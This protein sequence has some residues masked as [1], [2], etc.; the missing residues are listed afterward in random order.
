M[1]RISLI[2]LLS[3]FHRPQKAHNRRR[4]SRL[5]SESLETRQVLTMLTPVSVAS[6][7]IST[8]VDVHDFDGDG[9]KDIATLN[10]ATSQVSM[11]LGNGDGSFRSG[12]SSSAGGS[13]SKMSVS[14]FDHD[15]K[16]DIVTCQ[17]YTIDLLKGNGDGSFQLPRPYV[18]GPYANDIEI[19]DFNHDGYD[20][21]VT[22][23]FSYG[24]TTEIFINDGLGSFHPGHNMSIGPNG[25]EI[26]VADVDGDGH[27]DLLQSGG[28]G[29]VG[30][31]RGRGDGTFYSGAWANLGYSNFEMKADDFDNDGKDDVIVTD[32][33]SVHYY[34]GNGELTFQNGRTYSAAGASKL[35]LA[36][37]N[38]DG[39]DDIVTNGGTAVL[40]RGNGQ[41]Y[42]STQYGH[43][44]GSGLAVADINGDASPDA[45]ILKTTTSGGG[46]DVSFNGNNDRDLI[47]S[48][49]QLLVSA[50][51][52]ATAGA[53]MTVTVTALDVDGN[54]VPNFQGVVAVSG[55]DGTLPASYAFT[56][57]DNGAH[58]L[59]DAA[60]FF[61]AGSGTITVTSPFLPDATSS[62]TIIGGAAAKFQIAGAASSVAGEFTNVTV[63]AYDAYD[64]FAGDYV[65]TVQFSSSDLQSELPANYTFTA[66]DG[67]T[68]TF[69]A[70]LKTAGN[71]T[72]TASDTANAG[73]AGVSGTL[74]V[75]PAAAAS[76]TVTGGGGYIGSSNAVTIQARDL[77]GNLAT[78]YNGTVHLGSSDAASV[79]SADAALTNGVGTFTVTPMTLGQQT[80][81]AVDVSDGSVLGSEVIDV[82]PGWGV[83]IGMTS[84]QTSMVAGQ[85][86]STLVT[87]YDSFGNVSTVF[88][89]WIK[90]STSD[91]RTGSRLVYFNAADQ[92]VKSIPI[93]LNTAGTQSVTIADNANPLATMT[94]SG[95][96]VSPNVG[97]SA[98]STL[99][100]NSVA[101]EAQNITVSV[102][103]AYGNVATGYRGT[104]HFSSTD[105]RAILPGDYAF[106][107][108]DGGAHTFAVTF[109][110]ASSHEITISDPTKPSITYFQRDIAVSP[111][112]LATLAVRSPSAS[113]ITAG[114][115]S[116]FDVSASDA[117]GNTITDYAGT[118]N[119]TTT[120]SRAVVLSSYTFAPEDMGEHLFDAVFTTAGNHSISFTDSEFATVTGGK[121]NI[122]VNAGAVSRFALTTSAEAF[123]GVAQNLKV[124]ATDA[125]GNPVSNYTG[126]VS[127]QSTDASAQLPASYTFASKDNG[128]HTFSVTLRTMGTQ[129]ITASDLAAGFSST[130]NA[131]AVKA[132]TATVTSFTISG[133]PATTAGAAKS[134]TVTARDASGQIV[135]GYTGTIQFSSSDVK[136]GLPASYTFTAADAGT[137]TFTATLKTAGTQ[138]ITATD[139]ASATVKGNQS[140][141][142]VSAAA[143]S[144]FVVSAPATVTQG[145]GF[146]FTITARD[147]YGNIATGYRGTIRLTSS[148]SKVRSTDYTFTKK[149]A[150]VHQFS[151]TMSSLGVQSFNIVDLFDASIK[152]SFSLNVTS[153][154]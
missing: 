77:F 123:S 147:A 50:A 80:L 3:L 40:G 65:G 93:A 27:E 124:T 16:L 115:L 96:V 49:T 100:A 97:V 68:H 87:I 42:A 30:I 24:G 116:Q 88:T 7:A 104:L 131:I 129:T 102:R 144:K 106:T 11:L 39:H 71:Q 76:F 125:Y 23:S 54:V 90:V 107:E 134:F 57:A 13:G 73:F 85:T 64:N 35:Q 117:F 37:V 25:L 19:G 94:Q 45:I 121:T 61:K 17:G 51:A 75:T 34:H 83:R 111:A 12:P 22:A 48:A 138:T 153:K 140:G 63:S 33:N 128:V 69:Q 84:L 18:V 29:V 101:G 70:R 21:V 82:T 6:G 118:V 81:T 148:D 56:T 66:A 145:S 154:K 67:G 60:V 62:V 119:I 99:V 5:Q 2:S 150:G 52:S 92:G 132:S 26:E 28:G 59:V 122:S 36:D 4:A 58:T 137:H 86:Q 146:K 142:V 1:K 91:A 20:D 46:V 120:D 53:P 139:I 43:G 15:G 72:I 112:A 143:A 113:N 135:S 152:L 110:N 108:Q 126:T 98:S 127:F 44:S 41:F 55:A 79:M 133:F 151:A 89:G 8:S 31:L 32:G 14:D 38:G 95:I 10:P 149:D 105:D 74:V 47:G 78:G 130:S 103:D 109:I 9:T 136:A 141:I 114:D